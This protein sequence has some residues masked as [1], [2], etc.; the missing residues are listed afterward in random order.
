MIFLG[1]FP[2]MMKELKIIKLTNLARLRCFM[3]FILNILSLVFARRF[4]SAKSTN[5]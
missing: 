1:M 5:G 4:T 2:S 3:L